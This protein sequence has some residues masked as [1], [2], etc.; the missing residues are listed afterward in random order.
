MRS[1]YRTYIEDGSFMSFANYSGWQFITKNQ[2]QVEMNYVFSIDNL[3]DSLYISND[4]YINPGKYSYSGFRGN[5]TS[6]QSRPLFFILMSEGGQYYDGNRISFRIQPT[7]NISKHFELSGSYNF[8]HVTVRKREIN[9]T[10]HIIG[11]KALYMIDTRFSFN[12]YIQYN[13]ALHGIITNFRFR[14]N[15]KEGN[16]LYLVFNEDRNSDLTRDFPVLP[17]YNARTVMLKYTYTFS[18]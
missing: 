4:T 2:W 13:T 3:Q 17:V 5:A 6:P 14:Y 15:P 12:A 11:L 8:D 16:D 18:L 10:N 1:M 9:M 7:W